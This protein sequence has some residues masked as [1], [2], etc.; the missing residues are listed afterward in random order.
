MSITITDDDFVSLDENLLTAPRK[1]D[2]S[3]PYIDFMRLVQGSDLIDAGIDI[4]FAFTG[5][6][7]DLGA[8]EGGT[9]VNVPLAEITS[10][11][12]IALFQNYPNPFNPSTAITYDLSRPVKVELSIYNINGQHIQ[13]LVNK[14]K[15]AGLY[16]IVWNGTNKQDKNVPSGVYI[17]QIKINDGNHLY[18]KSKNIVLIR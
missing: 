3:L 12:K 5:G 1:S 13:T 14:Y 6:A 16:H 10:P 9:V 17:C 7:P 4:G 11:E 8:F 15:K 2:G 18:Q